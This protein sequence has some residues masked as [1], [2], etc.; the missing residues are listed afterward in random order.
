MDNVQR[1]LIDDWPTTVAFLPGNQ[2]AIRPHLTIWTLPPATY[3]RNVLL[4]AVVL[5]NACMNLNVL[6]NADV[7]RLCRT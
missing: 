3:L 6:D 4:W 5:I 7:C 1:H 2:L